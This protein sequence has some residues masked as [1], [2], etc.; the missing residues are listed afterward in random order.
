MK[1]SYGI[2]AV[3]ERFETLLQ[4]TIESLRKAGF[5]APRVFIDGRGFLKL[6]P[7]LSSLKILCRSKI[8]IRGN[9]ILSMWELYLREPNAD[10]YAMFQDDLV[11]P[12]GLREYLESCPYPDKGYLNL[13]TIQDNLRDEI[14]WHRTNQLGKGAVGLVFDNLAVRTLLDTSF[15]IDQA[16]S[17]KHSKDAAD[18]MI[19]D[20]MRGKGWAEYAHTPSL[21]Q[22]VGLISTLGHRYGSEAL[23]FPGEDFDV[24]S[25]SKPR[26]APSP[27]RK[28]QR[29]G[30][31]GYN[32]RTGLG[33]LNRQ[34]AE[35]AEIDCWL[36]K[37][38][39]THN[40]MDPPDMVD[41][42]VCP[43]GKRIEEFLKKVDIVLFCESPY[44][45]HF[46]E[47]A[48]DA[49]KRIVCVMM[50]EW[51]PPK[52]RGWPELVDQFICPNR[53]SYNQFCDLVSCV[54]FDWPVDT[55]KFK[56]SKRTTA[57]R[58]LYLHG[59]GGVND[60]KGGGVIQQALE[61][62]P[63][64][65]LIIRSQ[66]P[67][68]WK[69]TDRPVLGES[70][71][72]ELIYS[73]S[74]ILLCPHRVDGLGLEVLE[75]AACGMPAIVTDGS[76]WN[77]GP[78]IARIEPESPPTNEK[79]GRIVETFN[80][81]AEHLVRLVKSILGGTIEESSLQVRQ[82]AEDRAWTKRAAEFNS[83]VRGI[84]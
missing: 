78:A 59:H 64:M 1:W 2:T 61:L 63:Q 58:L 80:P 71:S 14:G 49:G 50:H 36:I 6:P 45:H 33:E 29:I 16:R 52:A 67:Q 65:P 22:H 11:A 21:L 23:S 7:Y 13:Y 34:I 82:W 19:V 43:T 32:C 39:P 75:A 12:I 79:F 10:R 48:K 77:E 37:P 4:P 55:D 83:I 42:M 68:Q 44:Y 5:D 70:S 8:G 9:W 30:L 74:D 38:H 31:V 28:R 72:N 24:R 27:K 41:S 51:M 66:K 60:R 25:F 26:P 46:V 84:E 53:Y 73:G 18:G 56:F 69:D 40:S 35:H 47:K 54:Q 17:I 62:F 15:L 76:P 20:A 3:P 81:S 57:S